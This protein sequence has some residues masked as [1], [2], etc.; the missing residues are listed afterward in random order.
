MSQLGVLLLV[1][2]VLIGLLTG[3]W[4]VGLIAG[5]LLLAVF[6]VAPHP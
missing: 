1:L 2:C 3:H 6:T 4:L 5:V